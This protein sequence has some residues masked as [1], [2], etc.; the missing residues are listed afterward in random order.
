[1]KIDQIRKGRK[2][3]Q[4]EITRARIIDAA[5]KLFAKDGVEGVSLRQI[6]LAIDS[7]HSNVVTYHF[8]SKEALIDAIIDDRHPF[9]ERRRAELLASL[10]ERG[11]TRDLNALTNAVWSP[12]FELTDSEG[13]HIYPAFLSSVGWSSRR[14]LKN[15]RVETELGVLIEQAVPEGARSYFD[16]RLR[17]SWQIVAAALEHCDLRYGGRSEDARELFEISMRMATAALATA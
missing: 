10:Q 13:K 1:V 14:K 5:E 17:I 9:L 3:A 6:R 7:A 8:G 16:E 11:L 4:S 15:F 2:S 12:F